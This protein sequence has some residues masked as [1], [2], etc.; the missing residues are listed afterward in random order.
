M[1]KLKRK[2][3]IHHKSV[4]EGGGWDG[5]GPLRDPGASSIP[6]IDLVIVTQVF[7]CQPLHICF[8]YFLGI[9]TIFYNGK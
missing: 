6:F 3:G 8:N 5:S 7:I 4:S 1:V 9:Y 2:V